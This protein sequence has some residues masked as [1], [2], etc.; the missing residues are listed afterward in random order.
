ML[1]KLVGAALVV[2]GA[3]GAGQAAAA[4]LRRRV[5][6]LQQ[7]R[8]ALQVLRTEISWGLTLLPDALA[9]AGRCVGGP[10]GDLCARAA[11]LMRSGEGA[12]A[13]WERAVAAA[14]PAAALAPGDREAL[15]ALAPCL[16]AS[17]RED[18]L[19]HLDLCLERLAQAEAEARERAAADARMYQQLGLLAGL[20]LA[21][22]AL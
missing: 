9:R 13:A 8:T 20:L 22:L 3:A 6:E 17:H 15:V 10:V 12:A 21:L 4:R 1:L 16:G 14:A 5:R 2:G 18:Q 7:A 19:R 11:G